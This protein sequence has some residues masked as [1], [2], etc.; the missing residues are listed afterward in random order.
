M[1][2]IG[3]PSTTRK[4]KKL[5]ISTSFI[6]LF[7]QR[8]P[9]ISPSPFSVKFLKNYLLFPS[10]S[11]VVCCVRFSADGRYLATGCNRTTQ[12]YDVQTGAKVWYVVFLILIFYE[13]ASHIET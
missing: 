4:S 5:L 8:K 1:V 3:V 11:S 13:R 6:P 9:M 7:M 10:S 12:I 2:V